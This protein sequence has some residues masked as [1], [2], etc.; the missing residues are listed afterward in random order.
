MLRRL[1]NSGVKCVEV[2]S[3]EDNIMARPGDPV[4]LGGCRGVRARQELG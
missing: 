3:V 2:Q 1:V 4:F